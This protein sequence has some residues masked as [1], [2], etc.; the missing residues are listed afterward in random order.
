MIPPLA[1]Q[2]MILNTAEEHIQTWKMR[3]DECETL[4]HEVDLTLEGVRRCRGGKREASTS[5]ARTNT[6]S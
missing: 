2:N 5:S 3:M 4:D 6:G 1:L